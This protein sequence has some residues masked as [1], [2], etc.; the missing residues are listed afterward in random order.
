[1]NDAISK[2]VD[3]SRDIPHAD[4]GRETFAPAKQSAGFGI[5]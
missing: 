1:L 3:A 2:F 5:R 4:S